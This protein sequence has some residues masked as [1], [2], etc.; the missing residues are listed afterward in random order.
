[1]I[2]GDATVAGAPALRRIDLL[3]LGALV[4][5][6][7][8]LRF[9]RIGTPLWYD[10]IVT[11]VESVRAPLAETVTRFPGDNHHP[12]YSVL[13]HIS[14]LAFGEEAWALRLPA[15]LFGVATVPLLY[16]VGRCVTDR[17]EAAAAALILTVSYHHIWFSQNARGYT[18]VL[19]SVLLS[20]YAL[21]RWLD[22]RKR[23]LLVLFAVST[24]L[25]AY[26]HLTT[27]LV[28]VGQAA[29]VATAWLAHDRAGRRP[30]D[31]TSGAAVFAAAAA[32][33]I[34]AYAPMLADVGAVMTSGESS[35]GAVATLAW[36]ARAVLLGLQV[37]F[38]TL[39]AVALGGLVIG[40]GV[41]SY[42]RQRPLIALLFI[43][44]VAVTVAA[45]LVLDR[46]V[47]PR[48]LLFAVG[49]ALLFTCRGA[50]AIGEAVGR[51]SA[52]SR[53]RVASVM[54]VTAAAVVLSVRSLPYGYRFP[55]QDYQQAVTFVERSMA[56]G[57]VAVVIGDG[58]EIPVVRY[59]GRPWAR[60]ST[61]DE[62]RSMIGK[63]R[64][65]WVV[66]TFPSYIRS[67]RPQLW[68][69]LQTDCRTMS[70]VEGTVED[71]TITVRRCP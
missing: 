31:W 25:G 48:F 40:A 1:M 46:P 12:L 15:A 32:L 41:V 54:L 23:S 49:F 64:A 53:V 56:P 9:Y 7:A 37:G 4:L 27:V 62:L 17:V 66:S 68:N 20:T 52:G 24:A 30:A 19:F 13:A 11:V 8:A 70:E 5:V 59:L 43:L 58:A 71:G 38:G 35:G 63:E 18:I 50:A 42:F 57:D 26:A 69:F 21:L 28:A 33:T 39:A 14:L 3:V 60:V 55:K 61:E 45:A 34:L 44:P 67:G 47:R 16:V 22:E 6:A 36:T 65:V 2:R 10:E 51:R 29:A